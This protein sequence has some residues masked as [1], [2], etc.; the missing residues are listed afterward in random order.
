MII[1]YCYY[2][3]CVVY[4]IRV[5]VCIALLVLIFI[6]KRYNTAA[7]IVYCIPTATIQS[8]TDERLSAKV[9]FIYYSEARDS[10]EI[11]K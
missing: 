8:T 5:V 3:Y 4:S 6:T 11:L 9:T 10:I 2:H 1:Y 7:A